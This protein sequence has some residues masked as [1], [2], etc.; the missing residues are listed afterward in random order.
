MDILHVVINDT[1]DVVVTEAAN[2]GRYPPA[3]EYLVSEKKN[4]QRRYYVEGQFDISSP[5]VRA[6]A[7]HGATEAVA[8]CGG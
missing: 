3:F 2:S 4:I 6:R 8:A 1:L 7:T 5:A